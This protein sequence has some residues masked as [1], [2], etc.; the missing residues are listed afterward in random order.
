M[1]ILFLESRLGYQLRR[2]SA[3]MMSDLRERLAELDLSPTLASVLILLDESQELNQSDIGTI[4]GVKRANMVPL[5]ST[6]EKRQLVAR[7]P[8]DG[9][10]FKVELTE[11]GSEMLDKLRSKL[12]ATDDRFRSKLSKREADFLT[13]IMPKLR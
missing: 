8:I 11:E 7:V 12:N 3:S 2:A 10:S 13:E 5:V 6:L 9:R 4:L 1:S